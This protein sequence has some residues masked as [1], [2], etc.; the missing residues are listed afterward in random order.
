MEAYRILESGDL[1]KINEGG[2]NGMRGC[3]LSTDYEDKFLFVGGYHD[4][5]ITVLRLSPSYGHF[6]YPRH[7]SG[8]HICLCS[9]SYKSKHMLHIYHCIEHGILS[10]FLRMHRAEGLGMLL[11]EFDVIFVFVPNRIS[12]N[13]CY[14]FI[15]AH[16]SVPPF[17]HYYDSTTNSYVC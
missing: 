7:K 13:I 5:K 4:G 2:I 9:Q 16:K 8:Y 12:R 17:L 6:L 3:Y 11:E 10:D 1:E 15:I 14:I